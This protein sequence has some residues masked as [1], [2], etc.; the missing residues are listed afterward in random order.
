LAYVDARRF[1]KLKK[2]Q[3]EQV[4][5]D[6]VI[7]RV[8]PNENYARERDEATL[9]EYASKS[10]A[11]QFRIRLEY[12]DDIP[13]TESGKYRSVISKLALD[14]FDRKSEPR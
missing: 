13:L 1:D 4:S 11:D 14:Y 3:L 10:F 9:L 8:V 5:L 6:E 2:Y 12:V 7:L